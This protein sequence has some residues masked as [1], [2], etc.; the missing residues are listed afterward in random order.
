MSA[1]GGVCASIGVVQGETLTNDPLDT[2]E[3]FPLDSD[4]G[5][6]FFVPRAFAFPRPMKHT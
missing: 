4:V 3:V 1:K 5:A 6:I 2:V